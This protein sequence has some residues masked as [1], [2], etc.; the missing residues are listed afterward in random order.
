MRTAS[1]LYVLDCDHG[2]KVG[3]TIQTI[4]MRL[5]DLSRASGLTDIRVV[6]T[7]DFEDRSAAYNVEQQAHWLLRDTRTVGEWFHCHP[8]EA[9]DAV[10]QVM[11]H[12]AGF[13][14]LFKNRQDPEAAL[15]QSLAY[16]EARRN[17]APT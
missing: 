10:D 3:I 11:R 9:C 8:L 5:R 14:Y 12:G 1:I 17:G 13:G 2:T 15:A 6:K 16:Q 7:W 4:E